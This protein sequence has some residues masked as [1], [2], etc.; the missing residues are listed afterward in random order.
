[1]FK[2]IKITNKTNFKPVQKLRKNK[3]CDKTFLKI[4]QILDI[5]IHYSYAIVK[6]MVSKNRKIFEKSY[7][8]YETEKCSISK[9]S[10]LHLE[11]F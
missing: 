4:T 3:T 1:M 9:C 5:H 10:V 8:L 7:L 6:K 2:I 11:V